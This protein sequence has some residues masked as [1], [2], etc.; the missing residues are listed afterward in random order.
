MSDRFASPLRYPGG[1]SVLADFM[2][3]VI[4]KNGLYNRDY[5]EV[6]AGG[7]GVALELLFEG[8][9]QTIHI[10]DL[11]KSLFAFWRSILTEPEAF[12]RLIT[13]TPVTLAERTRQKH[14]QT[15][16]LNY[17]EL[18]LGFSTFFLNRTNRSGILSGGV[19]GG[20]NQTGKWK[21]NARFNKPNLIAR[22]ERIAQYAER[23]LTYNLDAEQFIRERLP[24]LPIDSLVYL[25]PPY[26]NKG[27]E[28]YDNH[29]EPDDHK[30]IAQLIASINHPWLVTYDSCKEISN[31]YT[32]FNNLQYYLKYS[33]HKHLDGSE[34]IFF[35]DNLEIPTVAS[36]TKISKQE[37]NE[38][39]LNH[40]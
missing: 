30:R 36:P 19:I 2:K 22:I 12:C 14:I 1:K 21:I 6:Y 31:L 5:V 18:E 28:L 25:D 10:N 4:C 8:Y 17:S 23:I 9:V 24:H 15:D 35:S 40:S 39:V 13:S 16:P 32:S 29:Y 26:F 34:I 33:V 38:I 37:Y 3:L 7:A 11:N 20:T 27:Q